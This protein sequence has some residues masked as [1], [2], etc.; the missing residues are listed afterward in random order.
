MLA[1]RMPAIIM[2]SALGA[3]LSAPLAVADTITA[4]PRT[5]A[6]E[7]IADRLDAFKLDAVSMRT[8]LDRYLASMRGHNP[9]A[10][11]HAYSLNDIKDQV[12]SLGRQLTALEQLSPQGNALQ[13]SAIREARP[14]LEAVADHAQTAIEMYNEDQRS[15]RFTD[16]RETVNAMFE[17]ADD[18][19]V[20][21]DAITDYE[22]SPGEA[23]RNNTL[24]LA[25]DV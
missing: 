1:K 8:D 2:A 5:A 14:H 18:L 9:S 17:R 25:D 4:G 16:F 6:Q 20:K 12:N 19:Y 11:L 3:M 7:Q 24:T 13:Q 21:V 15:V 22:K 10:G 23:I